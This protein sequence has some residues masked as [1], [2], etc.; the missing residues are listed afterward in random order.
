MSATMPIEAIVTIRFFRL[1]DGITMGQKVSFQIIPD[2][3]S[4][5]CIFKIERLFIT[6]SEGWK[7]STSNDHC[8]SF[9]VASLLTNKYELH[10]LVNRLGM[11]KALV[12]EGS[13]KLR[14]I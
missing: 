2:I 1:T 11:F 3:F 12:P 6:L 5:M 14:N 8:I 13:P 9:N 10:Y 7:F 4:Y